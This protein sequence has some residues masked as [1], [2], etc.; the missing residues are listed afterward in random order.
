[1]RDGKLLVNPLHLPV[2]GV[3]IEVRKSEDNVN[4]SC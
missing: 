4:C 3:G 2:E 1:V